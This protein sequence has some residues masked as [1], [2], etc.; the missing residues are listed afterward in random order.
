MVDLDWQEAGHAEF[1]VYTWTTGAHP[2]RLPA[3][4]VPSGHQGTFSC[5]RRAPRIGPFWYRAPKSG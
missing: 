1:G 4:G 3:W 5:D 2:V